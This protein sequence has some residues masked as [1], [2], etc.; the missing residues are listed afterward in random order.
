MAW[1][2]D[3]AQPEGRY[4]TKLLETLD[5]D[6]NWLFLNRYRE[7]GVTLPEPE[8]LEGLRV[9]LNDVLSTSSASGAA[10]VSGLTSEQMAEL[11]RERRWQ[12][13]PPPDWKEGG[14]GGGGD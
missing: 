13:L 1:E 5:V 2:K 4:V 11:L 7:G 9:W 14:G 3:A 6:A 10:P 8:V 12:V